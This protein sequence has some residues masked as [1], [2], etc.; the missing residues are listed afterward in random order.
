MHVILHPGAHCTA[1]ATFHDYFHANAARLSR[2]GVALWGP[3]RLRGGLLAGIGP[4]GAGSAAA[5][6]ARG[7]I[8]LA[9]EDA[10]R[11]GVRHL[12][13]SDPQM[14]GPLRDTLRAGTLYPGAGERIARHLAAFGG[15]VTGIALSIRAPA[16][17]WASALARAV[18]LGRE[19]PEPDELAALA[20]TARGWRAVITDIACA[21]PGVP[22]SILPHER[23]GALPDRRLALM[24]GGAALPPTT[25]ARD[26]RNRA[27][28][29][30]ALRR[31][32]ADRGAD[33]DALP[34]G[35]GRWLP[36]DGPTRA[37]FEARYSDDLFW[38]EAG[39]DGLAR[40]A[41]DITHP[42]GTAGIHPRPDATRGR[43]H[44]IEE[45][46]MG[47]HRREG[48]EGPHA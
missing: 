17:F 14:L 36:F 40:L 25:Q 42:D 2:Q 18:W 9:L 11:A 3:A 28:D 26:W 19:V 37:A 23:W 47:G 39:A 1:S 7:R 16:R 27:P 5:R 29:L 34:A 46:R 10:A 30:D 33:A 24:L 31:V 12:I 21:A 44:D 6:R 20:A 13:V 48:I 15:A 35:G 38:L 22:I 43:C 32:L 8:A 41:R 4:S 45:G